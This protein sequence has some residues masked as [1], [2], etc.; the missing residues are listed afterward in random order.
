MTW[1]FLLLVII[2]A[3]LGFR[4]IRTIEALVEYVIRE[5]PSITTRPDEGL[6]SS[7][8]SNRTKTARTVVEIPP[9]VIAPNIRKPPKS[10]GGFGS[11]VRTNDDLQI[12]PD[13][14]DA[15][16]QCGG[17]STSENLPDST[18]TDQ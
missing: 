18:Q 4:L 1:I 13:D 12:Q 15:K 11:A 10:R 8:A 14:Q 2:V 3:Y 7:P 9:E 5:R 17:G 16:S 6:V